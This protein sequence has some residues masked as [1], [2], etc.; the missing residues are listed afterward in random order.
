MPSSRARPWFALPHQLPRRDAGSPPGSHTLRTTVGQQRSTPARPESSASN[1]PLPSVLALTLPLPPPPQGVRTKTVKKASRVIIE[2]CA[3]ACSASVSGPHAPRS[4]AAGSCTALSARARA[5]SARGEDLRPEDRGA[6]QGVAL[7]SRVH[8]GRRARR[9][10]PYCP[11]VQGGTGHLTP[12]TLDN[13]APQ[14]LCAHDHGLPDQQ[15][16]LRRGG[17]HSVQEA[18]KQNRWLR[19]CEPRP[20]THTLRQRVR[21]KRREGGSL[22]LAAGVALLRTR[23]PTRQQPMPPS[24]IRSVVLLRLRGVRT[25]GTNAGTD[26]GG[27]DRGHAAREGGWLLGMRAR[28]FASPTLRPRTV[29]HAPPRRVSPPHTCRAFL[30]RS[31]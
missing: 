5:A 2:K 10:L 14:V 23:H 11:A 1:H 13:P 24:R 8:D 29:P 31:T 12:S 26:A 6:G 16:G 7:S 9:R 27:E 15:E 22:A 3:A 25:R 4:S 18:Q 21:E 30:P 17:D 19:Y 20:H 28:G